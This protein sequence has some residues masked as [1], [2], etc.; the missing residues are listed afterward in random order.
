MPKI[1]IV[2]DNEKE[3]RRPLVRQLSR[4][5]GDDKILEAENGQQALET[6]EREHPMVVL[7]DVMMPIMDGISA[8]RLLRSKP[9]YAGIYVIML[10]G[11]EGGLAEGL[12]IGADAYVRKPY[13]IEELTAYVRKGLNQSKERSMPAMD[14]V[15]GLFNESFFMESLLVGEL[16]RAARYEMNF[17]VI[18]LRLDLTL[19]EGSEPDD[20]LL[21]AVA[22]LLVFRESD[23]VAYFGGY[24]FVVMLPYT[25][26]TNAMAIAQRLCAKITA[27]GFPGYDKVTASFG[28]ASFDSAQSLLLQLAEDALNQAQIQG[29]GVVRLADSA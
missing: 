3:I 28:I 2:D 25:A 7:L 22:R 9:Q 18:R 17:S 5:F 6:V 21:R 14:P 10:T 29:G 15:T 13:D 4:V 20:E 8:C 23:R 12:E 1:L 27:T 24:D 19:N 11:R 16:A 26:P